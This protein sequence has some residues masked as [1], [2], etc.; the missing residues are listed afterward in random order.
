M[1][2]LLKRSD[3]V[4]TDIYPLHLHIRYGDHQIKMIRMYPGD[5]IGVNRTGR[6]FLQ[7]AELVELPD[8]NKTYLGML[9]DIDFFEIF[10]HNMV[11][12]S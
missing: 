6:L 9:E 10:T 3:I 12:N 4:D 1:V 5:V 7:R 11:E 2:L 8:S